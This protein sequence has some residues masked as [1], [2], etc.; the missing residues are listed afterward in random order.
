MRKVPGSSQGTQ[1]NPP[2]SLTT[3]QFQFHVPQILQNC[4]YQ[5][6]SRHVASTHVLLSFSLVYLSIQALLF[7]WTPETQEYSF[8]ARIGHSVGKT[9]VT[10]ALG[11]KA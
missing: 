1:T 9:P 11:N 3:A 5:R 2:D 8:G 10:Q 6:Q 4:V 7:T